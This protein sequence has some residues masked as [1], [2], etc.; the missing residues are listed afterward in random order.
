MARALR[1][2]LLVLA[3]VSAVLLLAGFARAATPATA[4]A[5][6]ASENGMVRKINTERR[7]RGLAPLRMDLQLTRVARGWSVNMAG[8]D[9][10]YHNAALGSQVR[11]DWTRLGENVGY[12]AKSGA[13]PSELVTRLHNAFMNS[14]THK[15]NV[16]GD[17]SRVG[18]GIEIAG[19][20]TMWVTVNFA[21]SSG[22]PNARV[23]D[24]AQRTRRQFDTATATR[25]EARFAIVASSTISRTALD[26]LRSTGAPVLLTHVGTRI[27]PNPV[28][29]PLSRAEIDRVL[30]TGASVYFAGEGLSDRA[31]REL[32]ADGYRLRRVTLATAA[33]F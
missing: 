25:A 12:S 30:R 3:A 17:F 15:A 11:G 14:R 1:T 18:V 13:R 2:G 29:H 4:G 6:A 5:H 19:D 27:D 21:K 9:R 33:S 22:L 20:G 28:L 31:G 23:T 10:M 26:R 7:I 24:A 32:V 8:E 16:L